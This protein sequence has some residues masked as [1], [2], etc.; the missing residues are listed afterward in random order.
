MQVRI[1]MAVAV[2]LLVSTCT[3]VVL[4]SR[5]PLATPFER[6][7]P[8]EAAPPIAASGPYPKA[9]IDTRKFDC[10]RMESGEERQHVFTIRN[11]GQAPL[12][13][14]RGATTCHC[15]VS[16]LGTGELAVGASAKITLKW[17][18]NG[19]TEKFGH[20]ASILTNDP[21]N[22]VIQL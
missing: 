9:V 3:V 1:A 20:S 7:T 13:I 8:A 21:D 6:A 4:V 2:A 12:A 11:D 19:Q 5:R 10:G 14:R 17:K 18:P 16:E 15:T 22:P